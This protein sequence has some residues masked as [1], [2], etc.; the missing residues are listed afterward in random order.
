MKEF[1]VEILLNTE[2]NFSCSYC[3]I[4]N[5][6]NPKLIDYIF[7]KEQLINISKFDTVTHVIIIGGEPTIYPEIFKVLELI[8]SI[9]NPIIYIHSNL[10]FDESFLKKLPHNVLFRGSLHMEENSKKKFTQKIKLLSSIKKIDYINL[11]YSDDLFIKYKNDYNYFKCLFD[12][13]NI[14]YSIEPI[15]L[16]DENLNNFDKNIGKNKS[17]IFKKYPNLNKLNFYNKTCPISKLGIVI[18]MI[19][20]TIYKCTTCCYNNNSNNLDIDICPIDKKI[21]CA[22]YFSIKDNI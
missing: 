4:K 22:D 16:N 8:N 1:T 15:F 2:C 7:L 19:N 10:S 20:N 5:N 12:I 21:F 11:M 13:L 3:Y 18:N 6:S 9:I 17:F 14:S